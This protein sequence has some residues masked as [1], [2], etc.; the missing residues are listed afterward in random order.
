[1]DAFAGSVCVGEK[2]GFALG[3]GKKKEYQRPGETKI[4]F[5]F[6]MSLMV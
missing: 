5:F 3:Q 1:M 2:G 4:E 6:Y